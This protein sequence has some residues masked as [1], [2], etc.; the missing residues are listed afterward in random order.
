[1]N[2]NIWSVYAIHNLVTSK[3][4]IG[5]TRVGVERRWREHCSASR[6]KRRSIAI[7]ASI[8]KHGVENF[9]VT[10]LKTG[11]SREDAIQA[12]KDLISEWNT[13][14]PNGYNCSPGGDGHIGHGV[15]DEAKRKIGA[16][17]RARWRDPAF[18]EK[19]VR[20][21]LLRP[22]NLEGK[23]KR[24]PMPR[25]PVSQETRQ[26]LSALRKGK[27]LSAETKAK[28]AFAAQN[29]SPEVRRNIG[30]ARRGKKHSI[31]SRRLMSIN[32]RLG[33]ERKKILQNVGVSL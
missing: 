7:T 1:M 4:Y 14:W 32:I 28:I 12:E 3:F 24:T 8:K 15:T 23:Q 22:E 9:Y 25:K 27:S 30:N 29:R 31:E 2:E 13:L 5:I 21:G 33:V 11:L 20:A 17:S 6:R 26:K 16:A 19:M 18:R 10:T